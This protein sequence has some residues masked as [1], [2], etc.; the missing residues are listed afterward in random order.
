MRWN[1]FLWTVTV[2]PDKNP[3]SYMQLSSAHRFRYFCRRIFPTILCGVWIPTIIVCYNVEAIV[4]C[5]P[6][7]FFLWSCSLIIKRARKE[8]FNFKS[9]SKSFIGTCY[10][11]V[12]LESQRSGRPNSMGIFEGV[13]EIVRANSS[14]KTKQNIISS[15]VHSHSGGLFKILYEFCFWYAGG[16]CAHV[17]HIARVSCQSCLPVLQLHIIMISTV[18]NFR[19][20]APPLCT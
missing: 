17:A 15:D 8:K 5:L 12:F 4:V 20:W 9:F 19:L 2:T 11:I 14:E 3:A 6:L 16:E 10:D 13:L 18:I 1:E 7:Q